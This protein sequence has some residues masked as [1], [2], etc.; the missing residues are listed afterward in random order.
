MCVYSTINDGLRFYLMDSA[1][2]GQESV[3]RCA[4]SWSS[5][6]NDPL[7]VPFE[8]PPTTKDL[9]TASLSKCEGSVE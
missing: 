8:V 6:V 9:P 7:D 5:S 4:S 1:L 3:A 2:V